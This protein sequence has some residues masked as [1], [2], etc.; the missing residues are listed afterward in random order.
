MSQN[1]A[2]IIEALQSLLL[3]YGTIYHKMSKM[4]S[5][6][7]YE[8]YIEYIC[9]CLV[10]ILIKDSNSLYSSKLM[11]VGLSNHFNHGYQMSSVIVAIWV[12]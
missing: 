12:N 5:F 4:S 3:S 1:Y 2:I 11:F 6:L 8:Y 9:E 10:F 7:T